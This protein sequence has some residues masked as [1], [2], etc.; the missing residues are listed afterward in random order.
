MSENDER[1]YISVAEAREML[2]VS[3]PK[4]AEMLDKGVLPWEPNPLDS[5][6]KLIPRAAVEEL[7]R[8]AG[9]VKSAA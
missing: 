2:G 9:K 8:K 5:R 1:E 7:A 6:S 3:K 4:M